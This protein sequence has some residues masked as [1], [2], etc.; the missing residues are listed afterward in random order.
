MLR[1]TLLLA[2]GLAASC[3]GGG[4]S[5]ILLC[6]DSVATGWLQVP[7]APYA[8]L[9]DYPAKLLSRLSGSDVVD[10]SLPGALLSHALDGRLPYG[11]LIERVRTG[12]ENAVVCWHGG[13]EAVAETDPAEFADD[14]TALVW[15]CI[16]TRK[17]IVLVGTYAHRLYPHSA[18]INEAIREVANA[19]AV[20]MVDIRDIAP[21]LADPVHPDAAFSAAIVSRIATTLQG[22]RP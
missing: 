6:G 11:R 22:T 3:G 8:R 9:P 19:A 20:P 15:A 21:T 12:S 4:N 16:E 10:L 2:A 17:R 1:R 18:A 7:P 13:M 14:L 5:S